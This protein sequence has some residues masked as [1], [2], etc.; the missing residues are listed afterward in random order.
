MASE[1][2]FIL[3]SAEW[4]LAPTPPSQVTRRRDQVASPSV[5][6]PAIACLSDLN[7]TLTD[8]PLSPQSS[9]VQSSSLQDGIYALGTAHNKMRS[10]SSFHK[11]CL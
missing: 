3:S 10:L 8:T 6:P 5:L 4:Y 7:W 11:V 2:N 9:S 1:S